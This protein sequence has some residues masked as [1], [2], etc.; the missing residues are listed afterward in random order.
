MRP[1]APFIALSIG[2]GLLALLEAPCA[3]SAPPA[4]QAAASKGFSLQLGYTSEGNYTNIAIQ[5]N[6]LN[7][8]YNIR[9]SLEKPGDIGSMMRQAPHWTQ[10]DLVTEKA[11]LSAQEVSRLQQ[12][13]RHS[14]FFSLKPRYGDLKGRAYSLGIS[15][16]LDGKTRH[17]DYKM[18]QHTG[19]APS[20]FLA[21]K[22][23]ILQLVQEKCKHKLVL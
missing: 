18:G 4:R 21:V 22:S 16:N 3:Y 6:T 7:Y 5:G 19:P 23:R 20:A 1:F 15:A 2:V 17:V 8:T 12:L 14:G 10:A 13:L 9:N 11:P